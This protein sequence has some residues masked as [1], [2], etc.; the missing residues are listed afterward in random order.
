MASSDFLRRLEALKQAQIE[1]EE[2]EKAPRGGRALQILGALAGAAAFFFFLK[3]VALAQSDLTFA[4]PPP[5][6][7]GIGAQIY[8]WFAGADP[9]AQILATA[10]RPEPGTARFAGL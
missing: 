2:A 8:H 9:V 6:D 10:I 5:G 4:G 1:E 7:A 3:A